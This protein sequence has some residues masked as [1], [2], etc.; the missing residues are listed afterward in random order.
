M[1]ISA[2]VEDDEG[3]VT[4]V[5]LLYSHNGT[6]YTVPMESA[7]GLY[8]ASIPPHKQGTTV[9]YKITAYDDANPE[10]FNT[11]EVY[12]YTVAV[13]YSPGQGLV[14]LFLGGGVLIAAVILALKSGALHRI[15]YDEV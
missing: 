7:Y 13:E 10:N 5:E 1:N 3:E 2:S 6:W 14:P 8:K 15:K 9:E 11:S 4:S 12:R